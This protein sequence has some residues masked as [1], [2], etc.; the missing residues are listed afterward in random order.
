LYQS[1]AASFSEFKMRKS[2]TA[3]SDA[4]VAAMTTAA[5]T[6]DLDALTPGVGTLAMVAGALYVQ[7][8]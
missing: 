5:N 3:K 2:L 7:T 4:F 1:S 8:V 6:T